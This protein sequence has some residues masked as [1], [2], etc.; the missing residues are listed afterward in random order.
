M[1]LA[2]NFQPVW[3]VEGRKF[4][5]FFKESETGET[6]KSARISLD[7]KGGW[8]TRKRPVE[9]AKAKSAC[10]KFGCFCPSLWKCIVHSQSRED[11]VFFRS[12]Q[13]EIYEFDVS[14]T[15]IGHEFED[16]GIPIGD[17]NP[18]EEG[19]RRSAFPSNPDRLQRVSEFPPIKSI[20]GFEEIFGKLEGDNWPS[21]LYGLFLPFASPKTKK[22]R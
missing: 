3:L 4:K 10:K 20:D 8:V 6:A 22:R 2:R 19:I 16:Y 13:N 17:A 7:H 14:D 11:S 18:D 12:G 9:F 1:I 5:K 15:I 21:N